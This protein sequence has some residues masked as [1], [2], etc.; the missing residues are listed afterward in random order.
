M[1]RKKNLGRG[2]LEFLSNDIQY[3]HESL[4][5]DNGT[6]EQFYKGFSQGWYPI[7]EG[8]DAPRTLAR[9]MMGDAIVLADNDRDSVSDLYV[10]KGEAGSGKSVLLRRLAWDTGIKRERISFYIST[11]SNLDIDRFEE[12]Y[13]LTEERI[14]VFLDNAANNVSVIKKLISVSRARGIPVTVITAERYTEWNERCDELEGL[15]SEKFTLPYLGKQEIE[16]LVI[17][18]EQHSCL[19]QELEKYHIKKG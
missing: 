3:V 2:L 18:L 13:G 1:I 7:S 5:N 15:I 14:F 10:I 6:P 16:E 19:G 8:L 4:L 9:K 17:R 12:L 11:I